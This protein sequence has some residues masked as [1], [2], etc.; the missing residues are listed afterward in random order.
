MAAAA[1][2][3]AGV[4]ALMT[5]NHVGP[6]ST[7]APQPFHAGPPKRYDAGGWIFTADFPSSP[8]VVRLRTSLD[9]TPYIATFYSAVSSSVDMNVAVYPYPL[10][11]PSSVSAATFLRRAVTSAGQ[12]PVH[13]KLQPG[14]ST[15]VQGLPALWLAATFDGGTM[16]S[17]GVIVLDGHVAYEIVLSGPSTTINASFRQ[18]LDAFRIVDPAK[19]IVKF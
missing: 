5:T 4:I 3:V 16:A 14:T 13:R 10:G 12:S 19:G 11:K 1:V 8:S 2:V 7:K 6:P 18:A 17:F 9:G 15:N